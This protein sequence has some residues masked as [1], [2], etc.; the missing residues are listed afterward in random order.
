AVSGA[1]GIHP[2]AVGMV[3][4][5]NREPEKYPCYRIVRSDGSIGGYSGTGGVKKKVQL[6]K[7]DG[8]EIRNGKVDLKKCLHKF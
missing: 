2:R 5:A 7:K 1:T 8:I 6:L 4:A 3:L